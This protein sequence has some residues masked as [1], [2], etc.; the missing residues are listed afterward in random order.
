M[1]VQNGPN[2]ANQAVV[3]KVLWRAWFPSFGRSAGGCCSRLSAVPRC[4]VFHSP[5][6]EA[7][8]LVV[9]I[10]SRWK[11]KAPSFW[12]WH[13]LPFWCDGWSFLS[14][15]ISFARGSSFSKGEPW[16]KQVPEKYKELAQWLGEKFAEGKRK[17]WRFR[18]CFLGDFLNT[19]ETI[20]EEI[21]SQSNWR[22]RLTKY[23]LAV[24]L[25]S[26]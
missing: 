19:F 13:L 9:L 26:L 25:V 3:K 4:G 1:T 23:H 22:L 21:R 14:F 12:A 5:G 16:S 7:E 6:C 17:N 20:L 10:C 2:Q 8:T 18:K 24:R 15:G 11:T